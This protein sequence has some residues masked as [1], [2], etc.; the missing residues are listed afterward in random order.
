MLRVIKSVREW[1]RPTSLTIKTCLSGGL[2]GTPTGMKRIAEKTKSERSRTNID[3]V[4]DPQQDGE[5]DKR[6][7]PQL[8]I[9]APPRSLAF[10][11][12]KPSACRAKQFFF[13]IRVE[14][15]SE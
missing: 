13:H 6:Q 11:L 2:C 4:G 1:E 10:Q 14:S 8:C 7:P 12:Y 15:F 5:R 9:L 3:F